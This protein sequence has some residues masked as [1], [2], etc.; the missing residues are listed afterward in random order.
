M[1]NR[2]EKLKYNQADFKI[3]ERLCSP[4]EETGL[5]VEKPSLYITVLTYKRK[6]QNEEIKL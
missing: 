1:T 6:E 5:K 3:F 4:W 2:N